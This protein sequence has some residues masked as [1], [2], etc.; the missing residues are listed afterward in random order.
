MILRHKK[1]SREYI[2]MHFAVVFNQKL[3]HKMKLFSHA[4]DLE[5]FHELQEIK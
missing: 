3:V 5:A 2:S 4:Q 1:T